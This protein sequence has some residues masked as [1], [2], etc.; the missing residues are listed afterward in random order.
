MAD[1]LF[2]QMVNKKFNDH[3][4]S[5][6]GRLTAE[7]ERIVQGEPHQD[8]GEGIDQDVWNT[9]LNSFVEQLRQLM[10]IDSEY[11]GDTS[12]PSSRAASLGM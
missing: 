12:V 2:S 9:S 1:V 10:R 5:F 11:G 7:A 8:H 3:P 6:L 4:N